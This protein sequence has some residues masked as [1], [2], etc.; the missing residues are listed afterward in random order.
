MCRNITELRGL[1]PAA[2]VDEIEAAARQYVRKVSGITRPSG[3]N[4]DAFEAAV[5]EVTDSTRRLLA[6]LPPRRQPPKTVPPL[7]RP[8]VRARLNLA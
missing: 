8:E 3:A 6:G 2:T 5:A 1:E 7:R 4:V